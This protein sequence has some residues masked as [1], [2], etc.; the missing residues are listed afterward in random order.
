MKRIALK[1]LLPIILFLLLSVP[2]FAVGEEYIDEFSDISGLSAEDVENIGADAIID[3]IIASLTRER[4]D[5]MAFSFFTLGSL[6]FLAVIGESFGGKSTV[7]WASCAVSVGIFMNSCKLF[8][9]VC[10]TLESLGEFFSAATPVMCGITLAGGGVGS[11]TAEALGMG[12]AISFIS[13]ICI[14]VLVPCVVVMLT[15]SSFSPISV[16]TERAL[17]RLRAAF[18][19]GMGI[20]TAVFLATVSLQSVIATAKDGAL[21]RTAKYSATGLIPIVG[22]AVSSSLS[23][24]GAGLAYAKGIV[25]AGAVYTL[26]AIVI[27][28]LLLLLIYRGILSLA[29]TFAELVG[30]GEGRSPYAT[31]A[32]CFDAI[33]A[34]Y[35][36][37]A[38]LFLFMVILFIKSGVAI[39]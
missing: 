2:S 11:A 24:L 29:A 26:F 37:S 20:V 19:W 35:A 6:L 14:P 15:V 9:G 36:I 38:V 7:R 31:A 25:G 3:E 5:I 12:L 30:I 34:V 27:S 1:I 33:S 17:V 10:D 39:A 18:L 13:V 4:G 32:V 28:P 8:F 22:S 23:T 16:S 21:M